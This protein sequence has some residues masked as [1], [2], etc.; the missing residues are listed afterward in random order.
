MM[1]A[2][3]GERLS[4]GS[5]SRLAIE[6]AGYVKPGPARTPIMKVSEAAI[7]HARNKAEGWKKLCDKYRPMVEAERNLVRAT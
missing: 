6:F 4:E 2:T 7:E 3:G 5:T 1:S